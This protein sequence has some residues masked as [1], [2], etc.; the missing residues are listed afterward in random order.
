MDLVVA[1]EV[2][3]E[4]KALDALLPIHKAQLMTYLKLGGWK[5]GLL[6]N[7]NVP[8]LKEGIQRVVMDL[9]E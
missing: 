9:P 2:V 7:F 5:V 6:I 8:A 1:G 4:I 3:I